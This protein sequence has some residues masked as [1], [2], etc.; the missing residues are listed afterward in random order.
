MKHGAKFG[1]FRVWKKKLFWELQLH[2]NFFLSI[3]FY[4][5]II[6][7]LK[8]I[9]ICP[10]FSFLC[11]DPKKKFFLFFLSH[12]ENINYTLFDRFKPTNHF[13]KNPGAMFCITFMCLDMFQILK[14]LDKILDIPKDE[15]S[16]SRHSPQKPDNTQS[17]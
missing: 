5:N 11:L 16:F 9:K 1:P 15:T 2:K 10:G 3:F 12:A 4:R 13:F 17:L 6:E 7:Q 8:A 14:D